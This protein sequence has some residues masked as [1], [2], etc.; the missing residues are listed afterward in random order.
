VLRETYK[1]V[2]KDVF[3][4]Y[5][6]RTY[7]SLTAVVILVLIFSRQSLKTFS[8]EYC[9]YHKGVHLGARKRLLH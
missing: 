6:L 3:Y 7:I 5:N 4:K 2:S 1:E 9:W 8:F